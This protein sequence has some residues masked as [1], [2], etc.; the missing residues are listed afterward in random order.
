MSAF[1]FFYDFFFQKQNQQNTAVYT[2]L[3]NNTS[4]DLNPS[5]KKNA[6]YLVLT[7]YFQTSI[8]VL[9]QKDFHDYTTASL[10]NHSQCAILSPK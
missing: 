6:T 4:H 8:T 9:Q 3:K 1:L 2:V 10:N 5:S 7:Q